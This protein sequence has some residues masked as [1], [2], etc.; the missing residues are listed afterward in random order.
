MINAIPS[1]II[2]GLTYHI[3]SAPALGIPVEWLSMVG[4]PCDLERGVLHLV[5]AVHARYPYVPVQAV[6]QG[7]ITP[8]LIVEVADGERMLT[9]LHFCAIWH[10]MQRDRR[11][12]TWERVSFPKRRQALLYNATRLHLCPAC[13][14][15]H[16]Y[17]CLQDA[18]Q[19]LAEALNVWGLAMCVAGGFAYLVAWREDHPLRGD[20]FYGAVYCYAIHPTIG[21]HAYPRYE[22][23]RMHS[24]HRYLL[25]RGVSLDTGWQPVQPSA[26]LGEQHAPPPEQP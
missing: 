25:E 7:A 6:P 18:R 4:N 14:T 20:L 17:A 24:C 22:C 8:D 23:V 16:K 3:R 19:S 26:F 21:L 2:N 15:P 1:D 10:G 13:D 9:T 12:Q 11:P 5:S